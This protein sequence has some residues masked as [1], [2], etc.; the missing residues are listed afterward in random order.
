M[1]VLRDLKD[2]A[3]LL[4]DVAEA[5][6]LQAKV[7]AEQAAEA[8][9]FNKQIFAMQKSLQGLARLLLGPVVQGFNRMAETLQ[10][11]YQNLEAKVQ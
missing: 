2:V 1:K 8:E 9:K 3:P 6:T 7:T 5:G 10:G 11:L 4:K